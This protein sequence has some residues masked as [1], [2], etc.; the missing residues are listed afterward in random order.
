M[1]VDMDLLDF[2][3]MIQFVSGEYE[4]VNQM[5]VPVPCPFGVSSTDRD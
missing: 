2:L 3:T 4:V 5:S 1:I